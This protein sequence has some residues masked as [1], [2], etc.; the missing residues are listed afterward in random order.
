M[1]A[2]LSEF[3]TS[4]CARDILYYRACY[5][6]TTGPYFTPIDLANFARELDE[7][8]RER[9]AEGDTQSVEFL[10]YM[11]VQH[12]SSRYNAYQHL[13][14]IATISKHG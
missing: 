14:C 2:T 8:E 3:I 7:A 10:K 9:M 12:S 4:R 11:Q 6:T 5:G 1:R 13:V